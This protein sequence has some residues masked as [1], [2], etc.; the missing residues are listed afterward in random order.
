MPVLYS[1]VA[2]H[3]FNHNVMGTQKIKFKLVIQMISLIS[4][5]TKGPIFL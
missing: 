3:Y 1:K 5:S 2:Y 4:T